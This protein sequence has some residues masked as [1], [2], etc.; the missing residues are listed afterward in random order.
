[1]QVHVSE[2]CE[3]NAVVVDGRD[4]VLLVDPGI[5]GGEIG[6][7]ATGLADSGRAVVAGFSTHPHW[8]HVLWDAR[9]G[10]AP[11][12]GTAR[13]AEAMRALRAD[14]HWADRVATVLP[15]D[16]ADQVPLDL[17][18]LVEALPAGTVRVPWDGPDVRIVEHQAHAS[19]HAALV[20]EDR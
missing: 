11:R 4:G 18:G 15:P 3:S 2:F 14:P 9:L 8:D 19:G 6:C 16:I 10:A 17:L 13:C 12:Y 1:V 7:L 20:V 5:R